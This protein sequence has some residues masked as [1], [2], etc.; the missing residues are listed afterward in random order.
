LG[1]VVWAVGFPWA[2][3]CQSIGTVTKLDIL[4]TVEREG[5]ALSSVACLI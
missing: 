4:R 2:F 3:L 1:L 5:L